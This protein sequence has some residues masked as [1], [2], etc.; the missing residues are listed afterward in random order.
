MRT[1]GNS[2]DCFELEEFTKLRGG[3]AMEV[4]VEKFLQTCKSKEHWKKGHNT[5]KVCDMYT[6]IDEAWVLLQMENCWDTKGA[7]PDEPQGTGSQES[8]QNRNS[9]GKFTA[10]SGSE[11]MRGGGGEQVSNWAQAGLQRYNELVD[12]CEDKRRNEDEMVWDEEFLE[13]MR[14]KDPPKK[15]RLEKRQRVMVRPTFRFEEELMKIGEV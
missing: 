3:K 11:N 7:W 4:F 1:T 8:N 5:M 12:L 9:R 13:Y 10:M 2:E 15:T 14:N 6:P